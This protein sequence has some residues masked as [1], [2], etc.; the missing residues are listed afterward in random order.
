MT[1]ESKDFIESRPLLIP[2]ID[3]IY[4]ASKEAPCSITYLG[5]EFRPLSL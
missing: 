1:I 3:E 5:L 2:V 4:V